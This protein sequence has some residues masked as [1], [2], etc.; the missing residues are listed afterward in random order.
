MLSPSSQNLPWLHDH[1][2]TSKDKE[3]MPASSLVQGPRVLMR[4]YR[5]QLADLANVRE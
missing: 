4:A 1:E 3:S 2:I 5:V